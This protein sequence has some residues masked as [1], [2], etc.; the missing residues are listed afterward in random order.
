MLL[1]A[2]FSYTLFAY[3]IT[4]RPLRKLITESENIVW[5]KVLEVGEMKPSKKSD[6]TWDLDYALIQITE[7][8]KGNLKE[9][10]VKVYFCANMICPA[11]GVFYEG[12]QVLAFIDKREKADGFQVHALS[13]GVKHGLSLQGYEIYKSRIR[14]MQKIEDECDLRKKD[15]QILDWLV[16]CAESPVTRWEGVY[17]L[18][19]KSD[20]MS[21]Y[22]RGD[23]V[24]KD[25]SLNTSQRQRLYDALFATDTLDYSDMALVDM[26]TGINDKALLDLLKSGLSKLE[27]EYNWS[28]RFIMERIIGLTGNTELEDLLEEFSKINYGYKD[29]DRQKAKKTLEL[30]I[31]KMKGVEVKQKILASADSDS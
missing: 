18:S 3:P 5:A 26:V 15:D 24:R 23:R 19:P 28:A 10:T 14:E 11:P 13:Y 22:D 9:E 8:L 1:V 4:P 2:S 21:Y 16:K 25:I 17:E 27:K 29:E 30:F 7:I 6:Y 31:D 12:E 20:F